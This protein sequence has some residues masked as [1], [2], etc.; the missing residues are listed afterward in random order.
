MALYK[1]YSCLLLVF[2]SIIGLAAARDFGEKK[3]S[4]FAQCTKAFFNNE[5]LAF[6]ISRSFNNGN[7]VLDSSGI[8]YCCC[9]T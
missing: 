2:L 3:V 9:Q 1:S 8:F 6:C 4:C 5:C 7:C